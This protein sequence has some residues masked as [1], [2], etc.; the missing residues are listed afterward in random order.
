MKAA[1]T[2]LKEFDGKQPCMANVYII[3]RAM[4]HHMAALHNAP[5]NMPSD[6]VEPLEVVMRNREDMVSIN[7]YYVGTLLN[8]HLIKDMELHDD[9]HT[10]ARLMRIFQ[11][12]INTAKEFQAVKAE[13]NLYFHTMSLYCGE[14]VW[15]SMGVKEVAHVWWFTS[16][17]VG[18][19]LPRIARR[20]LAQVLSSSS[21][22]RNWS[23]Y[24]FV[25]SKAWN[26]LLSSRAEDLVYVYTNSRVLN[27]NVPFT[28]EAATE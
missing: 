25:H 12:L 26:R 28:D 10:M 27:Q 16:G 7:F 17:S 5:F 21:C 24:S 23:S 18:K 4:R 2:A 22:E 19:L 3:M 8:P 20:I 9:Q 1:V 13:F 14:H 15:S 11:R 6:L